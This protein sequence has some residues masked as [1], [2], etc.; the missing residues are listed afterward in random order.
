MNIEITNLILPGNN[1]DPATIRK[2]CS[3]I[4]ENLGPD[5]PLHFSRFFP[6]YKLLNLNP[7]PVETLLDARQIALDC[8]LRYVYIGNLVGNP[9]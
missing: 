7:T 5:V 6:M 8:G 1:D 2:M 4:R 9:A 3:W